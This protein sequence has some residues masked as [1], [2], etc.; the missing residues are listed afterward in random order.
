MHFRMK[1]GNQ[2]SITFFA[3]FCMINST[4]NSTV[5]QPQTLQTIV[6]QNSMGSCQYTHLL[7]QLSSH[8]VTSVVLV[9][10]AMNVSM[11]CHHGD[12]APSI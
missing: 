8:P 3:N 2:I 6:Y 9:G 7:L 4:M 11:L 10:C 5:T 12:E 1:F